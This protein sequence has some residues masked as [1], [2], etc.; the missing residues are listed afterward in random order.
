MNSLLS[1][2]TLECFMNSACEKEHTGNKIWFL[3]ITHVGPLSNHRNSEECGGASGTKDSNH[4]T[5]LLMQ[6]YK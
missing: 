5:L 4:H 3:C 6:T 1:I 2:S